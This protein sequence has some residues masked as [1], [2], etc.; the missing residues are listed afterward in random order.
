MKFI[1]FCLCFSV[2]PVMYDL[3]NKLR[4][5]H[6]LKVHANSSSFLQVQSNYTDTHL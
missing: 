3:Y 2:L 4:V 6:H 1:Y 5:C